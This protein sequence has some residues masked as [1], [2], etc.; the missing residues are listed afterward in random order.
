MNLCNL[1]VTISACESIQRTWTCLCLGLSRSVQY[2]SWEPVG[3][4]RLYA[5]VLLDIRH[6]LCALNCVYTVTQLMVARYIFK[7]LWHFWFIVSTNFATKNHHIVGIQQ[8]LL[9]LLIFP[10]R[11]RLGPKHH[12]ALVLQG[13]C[14]RLPPSPTQITSHGKQVA[15]A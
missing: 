4:W 1:L 8:H 11:W 5:S 13:L 15:L 7:W 9:L 10:S 12:V 2:S 14:T 6:G 3:S